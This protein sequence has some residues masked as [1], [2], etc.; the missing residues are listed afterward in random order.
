[1]DPRLAWDVLTDYNRLA[2]FVPGLSASRIASAPGEPLLLEQKG[3]AGFLVFRFPVEVVLRV[4][5][6][7]HD[8]LRFI[9]VRGN[10]KAMR[11]EWRVEK[12]G[13]GTRV[14]YDAELTP[15][16]WVPPLIGPHIIRRNVKNQL[17]GVAREMLKRAA[18]RKT[19]PGKTPA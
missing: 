19:E 13:A 10:M 9:L 1:M 14:S 6:R 16:F 18:A 3:E 8:R 2:E 12:A 7:P 15:G 11:G 5:E 17:E 4:E